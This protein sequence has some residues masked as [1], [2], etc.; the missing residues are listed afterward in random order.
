LKIT[1]LPQVMQSLREAASEYD[2]PI[3]ETQN[4]HGDPFRVLVGVLLSSRTKDDTTGPAVDRL[5]EKAWTPERIAR[6]SE[7]QIEELIFPVGFYR[8]KARHLK[9]TSRMLIEEFGGK[10]P[11][12]MEE[13]L[14]LPGI[15]RKSA[16]LV[17]SVAFG[18]PAICVDT[19][20]HRITN[21][22]GYVKTKNPYETEMALRKKLPKMYWIEI[23]RLL[24]IYGQNI[25]T[26]VS[27]RCS[28]C[29]IAKYCDK[30]SVTRTR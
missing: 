5:F 9:D 12:N 27:P 17:L 23:N 14:R 7:R 13:L 25:C 20:V 24:V 4:R 22:W 28:V 18:I 11:R 29:G 1:D 2:E 19:H 15:G 6:L 26:P 10:V 16:N 21:R 30:I 3:A 8:T